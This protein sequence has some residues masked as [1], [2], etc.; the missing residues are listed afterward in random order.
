MKK[1]KKK[2]KDAD[3]DNGRTWSSFALRLMR[4]CSWRLIRMRTTVYQYF[5]I[6]R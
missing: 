2:K 6:I 1:K 5:F 4:K 3:E